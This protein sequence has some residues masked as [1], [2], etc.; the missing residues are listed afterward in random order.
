MKV[1]P[2]GADAFATRPPAKAR[3]VLVFGPDEGLVRER[4]RALMLSVVADLNDPF[5]VADLSSS[6]L[7]SDPLRLADEMGALAL[8]GGRRVVRVRDADDSLTKPV[9][10][11]LDHAVGDALLVLQSGEL[12]SKSSL[13]KAVEAAAHGAALSCY[14]DDPQT[15]AAVARSALEHAGYAATPDAFD[16][17]TAS[18]GG[19]R[20]VTRGE[21]DKL[22]TY[23]GGPRPAGLP[24]APL[25]AE[26]V[27][28]CIGDTSAIAYDDLVFA[29][30]EGDDLTAQS[31]LDRQFQ[32]GESAIAILR[33]VS[34]HFLRL[35]LAGGALQRGSAD[36]ALALLKPPVFF[37][38]KN[39]FLNQLKRWPPQ[40]AAQ[41]LELLLEAEKDCKS[42]GMPDQ[43]IVSR[44]F[45]QVARAA[46]AGRA[47]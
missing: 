11:L 42:T 31:I 4:V 36:Q 1:G 17:L 8:G 2:E 39:R 28:A 7:K 13:R 46:R 6:Q 38:H 5:R 23:M 45:L 10:A 26:D 3:V 18:L 16:L 32:E 37:K 22:I 14:P 44:T 29:L 30:A 43:E 40:R 47:A 25:S 41:V 21:I 35:H 19:D 34:R 33:S 15:L 9:Q 27:M 12:A 24:K 20:L